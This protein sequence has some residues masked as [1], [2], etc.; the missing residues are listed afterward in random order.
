MKEEYYSRNF[1]TSGKEMEINH[2][3][4]SLGNAISQIYKIFKRIP[5]YCIV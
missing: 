3:I 2:T 5:Q 1:E 4:I